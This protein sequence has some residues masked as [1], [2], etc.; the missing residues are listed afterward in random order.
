[1]LRVRWLGRVSYHEADELQ[2]A[3][4]GGDDDYLLL[5]EHPHVVTLG[6]NA[7][8]ADVL[9]SPAW[10]AEHQVELVN[11]DRGGQV[12]YHGPG[13]LVGYPILNLSPDRRD[14]RRGA[15]CVDDAHRGRQAHLETRVTRQLPLLPGGAEIKV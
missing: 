9:V 6:R 13:Q 8:A 11:C 14:V 3:L 10:L 4:H 5:L 2:R 12:T 15:E 7:T 1:M